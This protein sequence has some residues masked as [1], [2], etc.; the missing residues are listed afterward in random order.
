MPCRISRQQVSGDHSCYG[1]AREL[2]NP[3]RAMI[4]LWISGQSRCLTKLGAN[5]TTINEYQFA[6]LVAEHTA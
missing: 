3:A 4:H 5:S 2:P 6:G 1:N